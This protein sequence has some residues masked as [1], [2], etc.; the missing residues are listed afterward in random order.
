MVRTYASLV[1]RPWTDGVGLITQRS[2]VQIQPPPPRCVVPSGLSASAHSADQQ[3]HRVGTWL[4][5]EV[6]RGYFLGIFS[7]LAWAAY[8]RWQRQPA[9]RPRERGVCGVGGGARRSTHCPM[10]LPTQPSKRPGGGASRACRRG[11]RPSPSA[12][13]A[14]VASTFT[15]GR[16]GKHK[17]AGTFRE[18]PHTMI[19]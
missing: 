4:Y 3:F 1:D 18:C 12:W 14:T 17:A 9:C 13:T 5:R 15:A 10:Q 16:A 11:R 19:R 7:S 6:S 8:A 2:L